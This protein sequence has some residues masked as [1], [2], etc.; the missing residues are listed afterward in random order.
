ME[1]CAEHVAY[2][3]PNETTRVTYLL[4]AIQCNDAS[5]QAA[6]ASV[7]Q[8]QGPNGRMNNFELA[9]ALLLP[10]CPVAKKRSTMAK[11]GGGEISEVEVSYT[12]GT[13]TSGIGTTGV[14]LR[15]HSPDE[16]RKLTPEQK[17]ELRLHR[18]SVNKTKKDKDNN[19]N[20][21][22]KFS[23]NK[24]TKKMIAAAVAEQMKETA[25]SSKEEDAVK[26][27]IM[28]TIKETMA[29]MNAAAPNARISST[30]TPD[31]GT[32]EVTAGILKS[33]IKRAK[34]GSK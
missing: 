21:K 4:D 3:L 18:A 26:A 14:S 29:T 28:S 7:K 9:V 22:P 31:Q 5:L 16:Y 20:K 10:N 1:A 12:K 19:S 11:R 2:Q 8:D 27:Y 30:T 25:T 32:Q 24:S 13:P 17:D 23:K 34:S 6:M 15:F 33:I